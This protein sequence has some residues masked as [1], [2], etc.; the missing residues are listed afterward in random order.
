MFLGTK[1]VKIGQNT[2]YIVSYFQEA[3]ILF[4]DAYYDLLP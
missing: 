3:K 4:R 1:I 2:K